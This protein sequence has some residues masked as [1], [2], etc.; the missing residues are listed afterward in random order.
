MTCELVAS[1]QPPRRHNHSES[2]TSDIMTSLRRTSL[3]LR[4]AKPLCALRKQSRNFTCS[5]ACASSSATA[6]EAASRLVDSFADKTLTKRQLIDGNQLQKLSLTLGRPLLGDADVSELPP[7]T[8]TP[9]PPGY[10]LVYFT[11]NG[12]ETELGADGTDRTFNAPAPFTRRMWAGGKMVWP[13]AG[14]ASSASPLLRVGD[15]VEERTRLLS[16]TP[17]KSKSVG[18]MVLVEVEKEIW[19]PRGLAMVDQRSWVFRPEVD[20]QTAVAPPALTGVDVRGPS[21]AKDVPG[22]NGEW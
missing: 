20:P 12:V 3:P 15:E 4:T 19:G 22:E 2:L 14:D 21:E 18:E 9:V 6:Q 5:S 1:L 7:P 16:A 17:K 11:S 8:G 13:A 10:H